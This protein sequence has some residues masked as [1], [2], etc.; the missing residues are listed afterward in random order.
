[1]TLGSISNTDISR[2]LS[3]DTKF[4]G[5]YCKDELDF[6]PASKYYIVN[7]ENSDQPGSHWTL[8]YNC[9]P[10]VCLYVDSYA[11]PPP[12]EVAEFMSRTKKRGCYSDIQLQS[13]EG[14]DSDS[15][16]YYC[17]YIAHE[18]REGRPLARI[19]LD[20][21]DIEMDGKNRH[22]YGVLKRFFD[23]DGSFADKIASV[24]GEGFL[25]TLKEAHKRVKNA[26]SGPREGIPPN[27]EK[28][29]ANDGDIKSIEIARKP[30]IGGVQTLL[31]AISG[32]RFDKAKKRLGYNDVYHNFLIV[33]DNNGKRYK[34]EKNHVVEQKALSKSDEQS[35]KYPVHIPAGKKLNM[36]DMLGNASKGDKEFYKYDPRIKN[37]QYFTKEMI[38]RNGLSVD[39]AKAKEVMEPQDGRALID[40]LGALSN[41]PKT[42][43]DIAASTDRLI[44]GGAL[45]PKF[46]VDHLFDLVNR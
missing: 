9:L 12:R 38:E 20:D 18:L 6:R 39:G 4:G 25:D 11:I 27:L 2:I 7:L 21:F 26:L 13:L 36:K 44:N 22:N 14:K 42:I 40:S 41:I 30:V 33:T 16:G 31:N 37:C 24:H 1:M 15:C 43:T 8:L 19:L 10:K 28:T 29:V 32:G 35:E 17:M 5:V 23:D 34:I 46:T 45:H 3:H